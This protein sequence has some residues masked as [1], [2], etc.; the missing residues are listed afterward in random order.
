MNGRQIRNA[1]T[2]ARVSAEWNK[3]VLT[4]PLLRDTIE[5][6][7]RF[8]RYLDRFNGMKGDEIAA[9]EGLRVVKMEEDRV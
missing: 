4:Y 6:A 5:I 9:E 8:D 1:I 7:G 2:T 3:S